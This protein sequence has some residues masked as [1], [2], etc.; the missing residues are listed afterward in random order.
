LF[1]IRFFNNRF[2][3]DLVEP[4][5]VFHPGPAMGSLQ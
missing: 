3:K 2:D 1:R 4:V 5:V